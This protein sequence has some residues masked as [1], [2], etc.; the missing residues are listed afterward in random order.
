M[1]N[2][3]FMIVIAQ[4]C[5]SLNNSPEAVKQSVKCNQQ[6]IKCVDKTVRRQTIFNGGKAVT[7]CYAEY[8]LSR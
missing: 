4:L 5:L 3:E 7:E 2:I 8:E 6:M 1:L